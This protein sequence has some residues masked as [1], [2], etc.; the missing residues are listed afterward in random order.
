MDSTDLPFHSIPEETCHICLGSN[1]NVKCLSCCIRLCDKC[2]KDPFY[3]SSHNLA[4]ITKECLEHEHQE[5]TQYC[6]DCHRFLCF[7]CILSEKHKRHALLAVGNK[8][9]R[10]LK[11][12][13][14]R[15][16]PLAFRKREGQFE[17]NPDISNKMHE[18]GNVFCRK[19]TKDNLWSEPLSS[20]TLNALFD[21]FQ[22]YCLDDSAKDSFASKILGKQMLEELETEIKSLAYWIAPE[23]HHVFEVK[24]V[25]KEDHLK[26][27]VENNCQQDF[28]N[29]NEDELNVTRVILIRSESIPI[30]EAKLVV[31]RTYKNFINKKRVFLHYALENNDELAKFIAYELLSSFC[32]FVESL[33][34]SLTIELYRSMS[35]HQIKSNK[36]LTP[37]TIAM[38]CY[39][40]F[41][42]TEALGSPKGHRD[43]SSYAAR[44]IYR[45][46]G[47]QG[48]QLS[49]D[50]VQKIN[51]IC[52]KT[53]E[54]LR[55]ILNDMEEFQ[56]KIVPE[57]QNK[58]FAEWSKREVIQDK[59]TLQNYPSILKFIAGRRS[60]GKPVVKVFLQHDD[61]E[62]EQHFKKCSKVSEDTQFEFVNV[63]KHSKQIF[64]EVEKLNSYEKKAPPLSKE[65]L[66]LLGEII[67]EKGEQIYARYSNV[68]GIGVSPV[69]CVA[70]EILK[71]PCIVLYCLD[72]SIV[73][74]GEKPLPELLEGWRCDIREDLVLFG[75]CPNPCPSPSLNF[76]EPGC[77][78]G[79]PRVDSAGSVGFL[80]EPKNLLNN[81]GLK[82]GFL[83]ASHVA[84]Q[85]FEEL[86]HQGRLLSMS[87]LAQRDHYIVH[88]SWQD[89]HTDYKVGQVVESFCGNYGLNGIGM[90]FALVK[91]EQCRQEEKEI[92]PVADDKNLT[93]DGTMEVIKSGRSTGTRVGVLQHNILSVRVDKS[94]L[95]RGYFAFFKC[96]AI[97]NTKSK[98][99]FKGGDSGSG[100]YVIEKDG[101][102]KPLGIAFAYL[103]S[104]TAVCR[105]DEI[106]ESLGLEIVKYRSSP[107]LNISEDESSEIEDLSERFSSLSGGSM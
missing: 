38:L 58:L 52:Q 93:F 2:S 106:I 57:D 3:S 1:A 16:S 43:W 46:I 40:V 103:L 67:Q 102:L 4:N 96:Y 100:V 71:Q 73:P 18:V 17:L 24:V 101:T 61:K 39:K 76:P 31:Y 51:N 35:E 22:V 45:Q 36:S 69:R 74:Y 29:L 99:F 77:S 64:K 83:T 53:V 11:S 30:V 98:A 87:R 49:D 19:K 82:C 23:K 78:I 13:N 14:Q 94:F 88:P 89:G 84:I 65:A 50:P 63:E 33:I 105:I 97:G 41:N 95:S 12:F 37:E 42:K 72:K 27:V 54:D 20:K 86:Y 92:L 48:N 85:G 59:A 5:A 70:G 44:F 79:I 34:N 55:V 9:G 81:F 47:E 91:N 25:N 6:E 56:S 60:D 21:S 7:L 10:E 68:I 28:F 75:K 80:V 107:P 90:D 26:V 104:Q 62:A 32:V 66:A 15:F 8:A